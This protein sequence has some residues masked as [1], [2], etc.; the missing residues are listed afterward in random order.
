[1]LQVRFETGSVRLVE[2]RAPR[3][4]RGFATLRVRLAGICNTDLELL[5]GYAGFEGTPGHE[6]VADVLACDDAAWI[7][8]RVVGEINLAC[9]KC[10]WCRR[11]LGRHCPRR[12]VLGIAGHPGAFAELLTLP[13][14][15]LRVVPRS[16]SDEQALFVE[17][18]AAACEIVEQVPIARGTRISVLGD[19]KLGLL[20]GQVLLARGAQVVQF[21][22]HARKLAIAARAGAR[23]LRANARVAR[24]SFP[25]VVEATGSPRGLQ[26]AVELVEPR[27]IVVMKSTVHG[28]VALDTAPV[29]VN[30]VTLVGSRCGR[31]EP[32]LE[33]LRRRAVRVDE[34]L[35]EVFPLAQAARALRTAAKR[36]VLKVALR[37]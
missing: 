3:R 2:S 30:E 7:G 36:G 22:R 16:L 10:A 17:P 5:H 15:N 25:I 21:G 28:R 34:L 11:D 32:A 9:G 8:E 13:V 23:T 20:A 19:G 18:L 6:F 24:A 35:D 14:E 4:P 26:R 33:L 12:T 27:G 1:M 31:F 29:I 37:P